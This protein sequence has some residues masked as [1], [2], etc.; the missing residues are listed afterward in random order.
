MTVGSETIIL[1]HY[2][3]SPF[4]QKV[5]SF[6]GLKRCDWRSV[7]TPNMMPKP[8]LMPLTGGYRRA[9]V[10]QIGADVYCDSQMALSEIE[11]RM[12]N[13]RG[14]VGPV[15]PLNLWSDRLFFQATV[16]IIFGRIGDRLDPAFI[17]DREKLSGRP[18]DT[19]AMAGAD[20]SMRG[21]WRASAAWIEEALQTTGPFL[22]GSEPTLIDIC[23]HMNFWFLS[24]VYPKVADELLAG[25]DRVQ[26]WRQAVA[27]IGEGG[28]TELLGAEALDVARRSE[29]AAPPATE[30]HDPL[31]PL[32]GSKASVSAD[33]YGR[34][35]IEGVLLAAT[36]DQV[37]IGQT[38]KDL[39]RLN[40]HFPRVGFIV[41]PLN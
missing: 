27:A 40:L 18:F 4:S 38:T 39:G 35:P 36:R 26:T 14:V 9:P 30:D 16:A 6:L 7:I 13:P 8:D 20:L 41:T 12:P 17:A 5:R 2:D 22:A 37:V 15:F 32:I 25:L 24:G 19:K 28:R 11:R 21:Q 34:D 29:P 33:D 23:A 10:M 3:A 1:H 31:K